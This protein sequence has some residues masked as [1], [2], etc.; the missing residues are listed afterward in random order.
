MQQGSVLKNLGASAI[1]EALARLAQIVALA[2]I[3]RNLGDTGIAQ[4]AFAW[5]IFQLALPF[6]Q[7]GPEMIGVRLAAQAG[8]WRGLGWRMT[9]RRLVLAAGGLALMPAVA[10]ILAPGDRAALAQTLLQSLALIGTALGNAWLFRARLWFGAAAWLR[11]AQAGLFVAL[12]ALA[13]ALAP[14]PGGV[15]LA[16][17]AAGLIVALAGWIWLARLPRAVPIS[18]A[19]DPDPAHDQMRADLRLLPLIELGMGALCAAA[20]WAVVVPLAWRHLPEAEVGQMAVAIRLCVAMLGVVQIALQVFYP[21]LARDAGTDRARAADLAGRLTIYAGM[22]AVIGFGGL[23]LLAR[24]LVALVTGPGFEGAAV[25]LIW[26]GSAL[27]PVAAG[28]VGG[29]ALLAAGRTRLFSLIQAVGAVA[30]TA[31]CWIGFAV[32]GAALAALCVPLVLTVQAGVTLWLARRVGM[33]ALPPLRLAL[34]SPAAVKALLRT[35]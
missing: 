19:S 5:S 29:Y 2:I 26:L 13:L 15:A 35:R 24:P 32:T 18:G 4:I 1:S 17:A 23:W 20:T 34:F 27:I 30:I 7:N 9:G 28:S 14:W 33:L 31:G 8:D 22:I 12:T 6:V 11:I 21:L 3:A 25:Q 10:L 16:E